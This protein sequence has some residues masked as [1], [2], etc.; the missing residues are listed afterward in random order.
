LNEGRIGNATLAGSSWSGYLTAYPD[1]ATYVNANLASFGGSTT[2]GAVAHYAKFGQYEGRAVPGGP[3]SGQ[4]F[5][6]TTG[7]D[8]LSLTSSTAA[9]KTTNGDDVIYATLFNSLNSGDVIDAGGGTDSILADL[10]IPA[11]NAT[12][13]IAPILTS[14]ENVTIRNTGVTADGGETLTFNTANISGLNSLTFEQMVGVTAATTFQATNIASAAT[15]LNLKA[16]QTLAH[17]Y[18]FLFANAALAAAADT[19]TLN[20]TGNTTAT[21]TLTIGTTS[22]AGTSGA[23]TV[24]IVTSGSGSTAATTIGTLASTGGDGTTANNTQRLKTLDVSGTAALTITNTVDFAGTSGGTFNVSN[25]GATTL[26]ATSGNEPIT[27]TGSASTGNINITTAGGNDVLTGGSGSDTFT[28]GTG[29]DTVVGGAGNDRVVITASTELTANDSFTLGDGTRDTLAIGT[30]TTNAFIDTAYKALLA[31]N[32]SGVEVIELSAAAVT[33]IDFALMSQSVV[34]LSGAGGANQAHTNVATGST[35]IY[36]ADSAG[37]TGA[38]SKDFAGALPGQTL[39]L[40][41]FG[42]GVDLIGVIT[43]ATDHAVSITS[44]IS[45]L[46]IDS[47]KAATDTAT[48]ANT[49]G[50]AI[51]AGAAAI[52]NT[53]AA[54][55]TITGSQSLT[56]SNTNAVATSF[57]AAVAVDAGAF[58]GTLTIGLSG[59]A[60]TI[61]GG[62]GNDVITAGAGNDVIDLTKGG[63]DKLNFSGGAVTTAN[64]VTAQG[65]DTITGF[66]TTDTINVAAL[67]DGSTGVLTAIL[68]TAAAQRTLIDD[69]AYIL[70]VSGAAASLT[71]AGTAVVSDWTNLTQVAAYLNEAFATTATNFEAVFVVNATGT[72]QSYVYSYDEAGGA[73]IVAAEIMLAGVIT[74]DTGNGGLDSANVVYA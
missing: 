65:R 17:V 53:S 60:D 15:A 24:K 44:G 46:V 47:T 12:T 34:R 43:A 72:N 54:N 49:I 41:I 16:N 26:T 38:S 51:H 55:V 2:N 67:G 56:I 6:L 8:M 68:S 64:Q 73:T 3:S 74:R 18:N 30:S 58:T 52:A 25:A 11:A 62:A 4:T 63:V 71:T 14:V 20:V 5:T 9:N 36:T 31:S 21:G 70:N 66:G 37:L 59:S 19:V 10:D 27:L 50:G 35:M 69:S 57:S 45:T 13:T 48:T 28:V 32:T 7:A 33:A 40:E 39:R 61:I 1:V 42:T 23:E 22:G 29:F